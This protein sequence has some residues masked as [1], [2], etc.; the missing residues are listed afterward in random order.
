MTTISRALLACMAG[1]FFI[2]VGIAED[3]NSKVIKHWGK[4]TDP[5]A[6]C[7]IKSDNQKL[8]LTVP[9]SSHDLNA[10]T[11][12]NAPRVLQEVEGDFTIQVKVTGDF[13]PGQ[14]TTNSVG[15]PFKSAGLLVWQ[16][17]KNYLRLERNRFWTEQNKSACFP[18]LFEYYEDGEYQDTDPEVTTEPFF[19]EVWTYLRLERRGQNIKAYYSN[20]GKDWTE[21]KEITTKFP[22]TISVGVAAINTSD[23]AFTAEFEQFMITTAGAGI[24]KKPS[25][26]TLVNPKTLPPL[27]VPEPA[28]KTEFRKA[29]GLKENEVLKRVGAP[30]LPCRLEYLKSINDKNQFEEIDNIV[31][32]YRWDGKNVKWWMLGYRQPEEAHGWPLQSVLGDLGVSRAEI[33]TDEELR[34]ERIEGEFVLRTGTPVEKSVPRLEQILRDE[35]HL[36]IRLTWK[37]AERDVFVVRGKFAPKPLPGHQPGNI[38]LFA[39]EREDVERLKLGDGTFGKFLAGTGDFLTRRLVNEVAVSPMGKFS[40]YFVRSKNY[41]QVPDPAKDPESVLKNVAAQTGLTIEPAKRKVRVLLVQKA[42]LSE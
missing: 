38:A 16:D 9:A 29:Y 19:K 21:V 23:K 3:K 33:E 34:E 22:A 28:W 17:E 31:L 32:T 36:P 41:P 13:V 39:E 30:F 11:G 12:M 2:G 25:K 4:V 42:T 20:N 40:W 7:A 27:L 14:K 26:Q 35:L 10:T 8:V 37:E 6:D 1:C 24:A 5:D 18:P 15:P